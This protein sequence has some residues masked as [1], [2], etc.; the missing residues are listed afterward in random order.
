MNRKTTAVK[1]ETLEQGWH[2]VDAKDQI[3]GRLATEIA[4]VLMGKNK[5]IFTNTANVGD[6]VVVTNAEKIVVTGKKLTD[7]KYMWYTGFPGGLRSQSLAEKLEKNPTQVVQAAVKGMLPKNRLQ[8]IRM[9]NLYIYAGAE[10]P[11]QAQISQIGKE[12]KNLERSSMTK[13]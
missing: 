9:A 5:A 11:H 1:L 4:K 12:K 2:F 6:K 13:E 8:K 7:K 3:L 10:H